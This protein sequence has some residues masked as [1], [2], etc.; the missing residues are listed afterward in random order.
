VLVVEQ[1]RVSTDGKVHEL[2]ANPGAAMALVEHVATDL[3]REDALG[4]VRVD[5]DPPHEIASRVEFRPLLVE[6]L[7]AVVRIVRSGRE[8]HQFDVSRE[9][10]VQRLDGRIPVCG[11]IREDRA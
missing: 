11:M 1:Q 4:F 8:K 5:R 2:E 10:E 3:D 7:L 9:C 6:H